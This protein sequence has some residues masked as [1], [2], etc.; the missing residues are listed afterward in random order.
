MNV[1]HAP[2]AQAPSIT[3]TSLA[4]L[5][6]PPSMPSL[7]Q[8]DYPNV[9]FWNKEGWVRFEEKRNRGN[10]TKNSKMD[11]LCDEDGNPLSDARH[12]QISE[13]GKSA[14]NSLY[15]YRMDPISWT[16]GDDDAKQYVN[17]IL[18]TRFIEFRYCSHGWKVLAWNILR[19]PDWVAHSRKSGNL[20]RTSYFFYEF[21][22]QSNFDRCCTIKR[23]TKGSVG[24][25]RY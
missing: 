3:S 8:E 19:Y 10:T 20:I 12:K 16:K 6:I 23:K 5:K 17:N 1:P 22:L 21:L 14:Y 7:K 9:R 25:R 24:R 4:Q 11:F 13:A 15:R 18:E 2:M